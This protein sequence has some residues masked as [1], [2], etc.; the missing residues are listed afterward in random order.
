MSKFSPDEGVNDGSAEPAR[1]PDSGLAPQR[2]GNPK[3]MSLSSGTFHSPSPQGSAHT[4]TY[5]QYSA[6]TFISPGAHPPAN[7]LVPP[8]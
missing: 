7:P 4:Q 3:G 8:L 6:G 5:P 2:A 1:I